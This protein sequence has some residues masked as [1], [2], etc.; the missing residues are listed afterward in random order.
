VS[1]DSSSSP[2]IEAC[3]ACGAEPW[4]QGTPCWL[5]G[6][7]TEA[8]PATASQAPRPEATTAPGALP[9]RRRPPPADRFS[10]SLSTLMLLMTLATVWLGL[11]AAAPGLAIF[12]CILLLPVLVR[13]SMVV[14]RRE[15]AGGAVSTGEK[16]ALAATSLGVS[17]V[18]VTVTTV[19]AVGTFCGL[20][21]GMY[22]MYGDRRNAEDNVILMMVIAGSVT[23]LVLIGLGYLFAKWVRNRYRRDIG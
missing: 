9:P 13:T 16:L 10:F 21:L 7:V 3:P 15:A 23:L 22:E 20:C 4:S 17:L 2:W 5:C 12:A 1:N 18:I 19:A 8:P 11:L 6:L 14:K